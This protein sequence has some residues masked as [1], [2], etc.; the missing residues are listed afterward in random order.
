MAAVA[1][2]ALPV[3]KW[4]TGSRVESLNSASTGRQA[5][6]TQRHCA[7][8]AARHSSASA[9]MR[10][11]GHPV[12]IAGATALMAADCAANSGE[13]G[14]GCGSGSQSTAGSFHGS[15]D[16]LG[17]RVGAGATTG[18]SAGRSWASTTTAAATASA[19]TTSAPRPRAGEG[20]MPR[21]GLL[22]SPMSG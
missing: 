3:K 7:S 17:G 15:A 8:T 22:P 6:W 19:I 4:T 10:G 2:G 14:S 1:V 16:G 21:R 13:A 11:A 12:S 20:S 9:T 18:W 5:A